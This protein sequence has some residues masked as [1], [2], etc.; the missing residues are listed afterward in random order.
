MI[1]VTGA[2][3]NVGRALVRILVEQGREVTAVSRRITQADVPLGVRTVAADLSQPSVGVPSEVD[4]VFLLVGG[5]LMMTGDPAQVVASFSGA[6]KIV[7]LSSQAVATRP[8]SLS[9]GQAF[10][11]FEQAVMDSDVEWT[12]LRPG[13]FASNAYAWASPIKATRTTAAPFGEVGLPVIDPDDIAAVAAATLTQPGHAKAIYELTGPALITP[14]QRAAAIGE[15]I[16]EHVTFI[17]QTREEARAQMLT[18]MPAPVADTTLDI[19][20]TPTVREQ[21]VS[22]DV[23]K[24]LGRAPGTFADWAKRNAAAFR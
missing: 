4:A 13:G 9:H 2:T 1:V 24:I 14:R 12:I 16:G 8:D 6:G 18:F 15:A 23:E 7:L 10:A 3:G 19:L 5:D 21:T 11:A 17:D 20:G 22:P